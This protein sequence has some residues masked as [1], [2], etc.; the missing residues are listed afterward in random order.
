LCL[1]QWPHAKARL[2]G[3]SDPPCCR[4]V[5]CSRWKHKAGNADCGSPQYSQQSR[6]R[7]RIRLDYVSLRPSG[8][9]AVG[10]YS[11]RL[12]LQDADQ[13]ERLQ[14][15]VVFISFRVGE[16]AFVEIERA[17]ANVDR[18]PWS[19]P[20]NLAAPEAI[21]HALQPRFARPTQNGRA[22]DTLATGGADLL[23]SAASH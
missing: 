17:A 21:G 11:H 3:S 7:L 15:V 18:T 20:F 23:A 1:L 4:A 16:L 19:I 8:M 22:R 5:M 10:E 6:A 9:S 12:P 2:L 14:I 13:V